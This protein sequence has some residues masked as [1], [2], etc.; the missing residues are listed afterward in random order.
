MILAGIIAAKSKPFVLHLNVLSY[1]NYIITFRCVATFLVKVELIKLAEENVNASLL[2]KVPHLSALD[3]K[4]H[5][6]QSLLNRTKLFSRISNVQ[7]EESQ[8]QTSVPWIFSL[9]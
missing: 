6:M 4:N 3:S 8:F 7:A 2:K 1:N 9:F 5:F